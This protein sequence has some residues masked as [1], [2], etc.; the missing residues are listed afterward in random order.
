MQ[1]NK[2]KVAVWIVFTCIAIIIWYLASGYK[3]T[4][5]KIQGL[6]GGNIDRAIREEQYR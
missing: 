5:E 4:E 6:Q 2:D 3:Y 1:Y